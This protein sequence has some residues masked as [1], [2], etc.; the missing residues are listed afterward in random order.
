MNACFTQMRN[1]RLSNKLMNT[2]S[3]LLFGLCLMV[4]IYVLPASAQTTYTENFTNPTTTNS[5]FFLNGACLTA[6]TTST[7]A[8]ANPACVGLAYYPGKG[9]NNLKGGATGILPDPTA[10]GAL[11]FT[12]SYNENGAILSNFNFPLSSQGLAVS[13]TTVTYEGDSGGGGHDGADGISFF[14][15]DASYVADVG[16]FGGSLAYTCS[17]ANND[18]TLSV[19][20]G[21]PRGY[22]G[23]NGGY[24]GLGIDEYGNFLNQGDNT[25]SGYGYQP[26]RIG[27]R[28]SG[29]VTWQSLNSTYPTQYPS[30][31]TTAQ[32]AAAVQKACSTGIVANFAGGSAAPYLPVTPLQ[33]ISTTGSKFSDYAAH[34]GGLQG[35]AFDAAHCQRIGDHAFPGGA[36]NLQLVHNPGRAA[37]S[38]LQLQRR[39]FPIGHHGRRYHAEKLFWRADQSSSRIDSVWLCRIH[40]RQYQYSR[41]HVFSS[42]TDGLVV[43]FGR[44]EPAPKRKDTD[45]ISS[46]LGLLQSAELVRFPD[47]AVYRSEHDRC[48]CAQHRFDHQLGWIVRADGRA[49]R[50]NL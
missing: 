45:R 5:W 12:N 38:R 20:T 42:D 8:A 30:T 25:A 9:D 48:E 3:S 34:S 22:D 6:G 28:G 32:R 49:E 11:R 13:F 35:I 10:R 44:R 23:I 18:G 47:I 39:C 7:T 19:V 16:A 24:I 15:Q 41:N 29:S 50:S 26:G 21:R 17:N 36:Y 27:L 33:F 2:K 31:L 40:W 46:L 43:E 4:T 1:Q 14:L 37:Q